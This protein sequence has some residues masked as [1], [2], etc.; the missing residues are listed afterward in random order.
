MFIELM[1]EKERKI[2][3][4]E[5]EYKKKLDSLFESMSPEEIVVNIIIEVL[6]EYNKAFDD[7]DKEIF[8]IYPCSTTTAD[9]LAHLYIYSK[10]RVYWRI[11]VC[12]GYGYFDVVGLSK[13][14]YFNIKRKLNGYR[15]ADCKW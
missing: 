3:E 8:S 4:A 15:F 12:Y 1:K 10:D 9:H 14:Q 13:E 11:S 5:K 2:G 7:D 6:D